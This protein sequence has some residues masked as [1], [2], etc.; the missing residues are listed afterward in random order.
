[1]TPT[2]VAGVEPLAVLGSLTST[3][4]NCHCHAV[5]LEKNRER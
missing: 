4:H 3:S 1:M 5:F 2:Q